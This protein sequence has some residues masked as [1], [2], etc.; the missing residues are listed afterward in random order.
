M[1]IHFCIISV[2]ITQG[3]INPLGKLE[4][5]SV[6][7]KQTTLVSNEHQHKQ[8][9]RLFSPFSYLAK[10]LKKKK[11]RLEIII[12]HNIPL[13]KMLYYT[14]IYNTHTH[15]YSI[16]YKKRFVCTL[17]HTWL[18]ATPWTVAFQAPL[19]I[20]YPREEYWSEL[21]LPPPDHLP[22]SGIK[23]LSTV[24]AVLAG[25]SLLL[26]HLGSPRKDTDKA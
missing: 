19:S 15:I 10:C 23:L 14:Y 5:F 22:D 9:N 21:P 8:G 4:I 25:W 3:N 26:C 17:S 13:Y 11:K 7:Y 20:G 18:F 16:R 6:A 2:L 12:P 24:S 1:S